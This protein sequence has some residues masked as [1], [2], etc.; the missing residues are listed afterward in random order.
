[1]LAERLGSEHVQ[2]GC[3]LQVRHGAGA[4]LEHSK[5]V[6]AA[7]LELLQKTLLA[8][9]MRLSGGSRR[10]ESSRVVFNGAGLLL[11]GIFLPE[12]AALRVDAAAYVVIAVGNA[13]HSLVVDILMGS[14]WRLRFFPCTDRVTPSL[15]RGKSRCLID[16]TLWL[17]AAAW[18]DTIIVR[19]DTLS[20][21]PICERSH[22]L[23]QVRRML[24]L[25]ARQL[26]MR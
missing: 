12:W 9:E 4:R 15:N 10:C 20:T 24:G 17:P 18:H 25:P 8:A 13:V 7:C 2:R 5:V 22:Q 6:L 11:D 26:L 21:S 23:Y 16:G 14:A 1:M 19:S 3:I